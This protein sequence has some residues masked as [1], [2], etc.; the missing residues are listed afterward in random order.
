MKQLRPNIA[1]KKKTTVTC[2]MIITTIATPTVELS[3]E[4]TCCYPR[5]FHTEMYHLNV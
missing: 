5:A 4:A 2:S 3:S 1:K